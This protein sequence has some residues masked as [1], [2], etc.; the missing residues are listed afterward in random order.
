M[1]TGRTN[2]LM[3]SRKGIGSRGKLGRRNLAMLLILLGALTAAVL[4]NQLNPRSFEDARAEIVALARQASTLEEFQAVV[5][6]HSE[7]PTTKA[8]GGALGWLTQSGEGLEQV[9]AHAFSIHAGGLKTDRKLIGPIDLPSGV[10]MCWVQDWRPAPDW[11]T[12]REHVT[13]ELRRRFVDELCPP[14][15]W[16]TYLDRP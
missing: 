5:A 13:K 9:R 10:A 1:R 11:G 4:P 2:R 3:E 6:S 15:G 14:D 16:T 8:R 12:M 7:D